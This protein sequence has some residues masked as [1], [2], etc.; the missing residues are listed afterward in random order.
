MGGV[1]AGA[2]ALLV[3]G[4]VVDGVVATAFVTT[5][6]QGAD[7]RILGTM[8]KAQNNSRLTQRTMA[9]IDLRS[10]LRGFDI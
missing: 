8:T 10:M 6:G 5:G 2:S 1:M 4:A 7:G 3:A 9:V